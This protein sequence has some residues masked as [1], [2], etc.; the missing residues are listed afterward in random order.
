MEYDPQRDAVVTQLLGTEDY[1]IWDV[2]V[3]APDFDDPRRLRAATKVQIDWEPGNPALDLARR[4]MVLTYV[5]NR[6]SDNPL[7]ETFDLDS[8]S[9]LASYTR[10][11]SRLEMSDFAAVDP[12]T[13][14]W[15]VP[16]YYDA[17]RFVLVEFDVKTGLISRQRETA[18]GS[19]GLATEAGRLY[20]T[21]SL[22]GGLY[23]YDLADLSVTQ[24]LPAGRFP[25]D[26]V[27]DRARHRLY[28]GGYADGIVRAW[29][30][31]GPELEPL[32]EVQVGSLL[33]G[34]GLEPETG[35]VFAASGCGLFEVAAEGGAQLR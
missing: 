28:V 2:R 29:S 24:V 23:V 8:F 26:L 5:P 35:R 16:A 25:R 7:F 32:F 34:L 21:S 1:A 22:A 3:K 27:L 33:R 19:I 4:R 30:T 20:L 15:Y 9:R 13:G 12:D 6:V 10:Y 31:D 17:V 18:F 14:H 11:G